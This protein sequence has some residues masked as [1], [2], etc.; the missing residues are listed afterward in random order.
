MTNPSY[1]FRNKGRDTH[2]LFAVRFEDGRSAYMRVDPKSA[3][4]GTEIIK[5]L[6]RSR[7]EQGEL[8]TGTIAALVRVK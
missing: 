1:P 4:Q 3:A 8:P 7:Q 2:V 6:A 5:D